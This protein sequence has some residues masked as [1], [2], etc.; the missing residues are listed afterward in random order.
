M[1]LNN[2]QSAI[3]MLKSIGRIFNADNWAIPVWR[4][5]SNVTD[6]K[7]RRQA[8]SVAGFPCFSDN[9]GPDT[10]RI[11]DRNGKRQFQSAQRHQL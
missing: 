3:K 11:T 6:S 5:T 8:R 9:L 4:K 2:R 1:Q 10:S 7:K